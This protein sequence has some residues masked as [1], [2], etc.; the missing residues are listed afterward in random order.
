MPRPQENARTGPGY[1]LAEWLN[2]NWDSKV[3]MTNEEAAQKMDY[4]STNIVSMWRTGKTK[5][6]LERLPEVADLMGVDFIT[7]LPLWVEQYMNDDPG[8]KG[9]FHMRRVT[10]AFKRLATINEFPVLK[11]IRSVF[12]RTNPD[13]T[14]EQIEA[15]R[16]VA[17]N[18]EFAAFVLEEARRQELINEI[19]VVEDETEAATA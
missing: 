11:A 6:A 14:P 12:G 9:A 18:Q 10:A 7:L 15:F 4:R 5:V 13:F 19:A 1:R 16:Q 17:A 8:T 2:A 3:G